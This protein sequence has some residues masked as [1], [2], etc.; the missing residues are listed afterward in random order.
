MSNPDAKPEITF[1]GISASPGIAYGP[2]FVYRKTELEIPEYN[3][4]EDKIAAEF[5]RFEQAL[6]ITRDQITKIRDEVEADLGAEEAR[7]FDA[8]LLV[9][10]DQ[11]LITETEREIKSTGRNVEFCFDVVSQ[12]YIRAFDQID[13][14]YLRERAGDIRDVTQ[15]LLRNLTGQTAENLS[16]LLGRRIVVAIDIAPS[17][18]ASLDR[19]AAMGLVTESGSKTSHAVIVARS[20]KIPAVVGAR[21][22]MAALQ[23][24]E[25]VIVDG[26]DGVVIVHPSEQTLFRYGQLREEKQTLEKS[27]LAAAHEP[28]VTRDGHEVALRANIEK[29]DEVDL[30]KQH[31]GDGVGLFRSEFLYLASPQV[32][33]EEQQFQAY[34]HVVEAFD[35]RPVVIRTLDLGGDK[36]MTGATHLFP[37]EDNPFLG[38]RAIRFCLEH[39][40]IFRAQLRA[41]LRASAFGNLHLMFPMISGTKEM[42]LATA[43]LKSC[44]EELRHEGVVFNES[45]PVGT[46]IEV[47]SAALTA[48]TLAEECDF[49]SIGTNDLIQYL[50]AID[51]IN[52]RTAHLYEPTHPAVVRI[53]KE[54]VDKGHAAGIKI[55]VCGEMAGDPIYVPL[56]L[57][58]GV[59]ELSMTPPLLPAAKYLVRSMTIEDARQLAADALVSVSAETTE[60]RCLQ[61]YRERMRLL[62]GETDG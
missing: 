42:R 6:L 62:A 18:A 22:V 47:P 24:D 60:E 46:M 11:A 45:M 10:E 28:S 8:H 13:D 21:D 29:A 4:D 34:K 20:M 38:F 17:D 31:G 53:I 23:G 12:R 26:Y 9:L 56:L 57:G 55:S 58:L 61:F 5:Q 48:D 44:Q 27:L 2:V 37:R 54:V 7:I 36:P 52:D 41:L 25:K 3:I 33:T 32:P 59:D 43:V 16:E 40:D 30:V 35:G 39:E 51:R 49:F 14:E 1:Y 15:R 19:S 50:I